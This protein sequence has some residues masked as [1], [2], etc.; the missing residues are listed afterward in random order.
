MPRPHF[1]GIPWGRLLV[2]ATAIV[3][4]ILLAFAIDATW[5]ERQERRDEQEV[6]LALKADFTDNR[7]GLEQIIRIHA[8][9]SDRLARL[10]RMSREE[11]LA[12][13]VDSV[14][15][16]IAVLGNPAT[17]DPVRGSVDA[18]IGA[19]NMRLLRDERLRQSLTGFLNSVEDAREDARYM[20]EFAVK[21]WER[22]VAHGGP[23]D[24]PF[25]RENWRVGYLEEPTAR[26]LAELNADRNLMG[27]AAQL[28]VNATLYV[29]ELKKMAVQV[30]GILD[31]VEG[32]I[33]E[34]A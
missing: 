4:S 17:F 3:L 25:G 26:D 33:R 13:E 22:I 24:V 8:A 5:D 34:E 30:E 12:L 2:E 10:D 23:W 27:L 29:E 1:D 9:A 18:L 32:G 31:M 6:L 16:F 28:R 11:V 7:A 19:G 14:A 15:V 20:G 21:I